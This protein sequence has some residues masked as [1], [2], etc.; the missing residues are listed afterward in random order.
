MVSFRGV[1]A[2]KEKI[3][4]KRKDVLL[5]NRASHYYHIVV[6]AVNIILRFF[7][8]RLAAQ[9]QFFLRVYF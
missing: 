2:S 1:I 5:Q 7:R 8:L 9:M 3:D 4:S 6:C